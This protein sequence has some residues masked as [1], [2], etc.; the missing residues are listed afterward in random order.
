MALSKRDLDELRPV[1]QSSVLKVL[2]I[3]EPSVVIAAVN[4]IGQRMSKT[5]TVDM[6]KPLLEDSAERFVETLFVDVAGFQVGNRASKRTTKEDDGYEG[7][8]KRSKLSHFPGEEENGVKFAKSQPEALR[9][10]A[11][12]KA[13]KA[14][15]IQARIQATMM[16]AGLGGLKLPPMPGIP[17]APAIPKV[18]ATK[19][20]IS[21]MKSPPS[22][23]TKPA[24]LILD[25][26]G[27]TIDKSGR[28]II[29]PQHRPTIKANIRAKRREEFKVNQQEKPQDLSSDSNK[30]F[31]PRVVP[32]VGRGN[33]KSFKFHDQGKF[34]QVAQ[35]I[36]AK[37]QLE[38]L[39]NEISQAAK[40]T[41]IT[42]ATKL[43]LITPKRELK[44]NEIPGVEWWDSFILPTETYADVSKGTA[45]A[46]G[47]DKLVGITNLVEHPIQIEPPAEKKDV[48]L[49]IYLTKK[50]MKK[51]RRQRRREA[52]KE[53]TEKIRMGLEPPP[54]PKV[55]M[56]NLMRVLGT[57]A[58]QDPTKVEAHVRAQMEKRQRTHEE[59]NAARK[60]TTEQR[61]EKKE[62]KMREDTSTGVTV[63]VYRVLNLNNPAKRFK[64]EANAKQ[65]QMTGIAVVHK[66]MNC[67]V[68]EGGPKQQKKFQRLMLHRIKWGEDKRSK[69]DD[70]DSGDEAVKSNHCQLMWSGMIKQRNFSDLHFKLC[71]TEAMAR[72]QFK[73]HNVEHYWGLVHSQSVLDSTD[74]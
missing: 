38:K 68:V 37:S 48:E 46:S 40:K 17:Q 4:C 15:E 22:V 50:E 31:D 65:L 59:T 45:Q 54:E 26:Q 56:A 8:K 11:L 70:D 28:V 74:T 2:G 60:L 10:D 23:L 57:E 13:K 18:P 20:D 27:R 62:R 21:D 43:A 66:D 1:V 5:K 72:E 52:L 58:V 63:N 41:G 64:V 14:A 42:S 30:F 3:N 12:E 32:V 29:L 49:P 24:P 36:R 39:Q 73:K 33:R 44:E 71:P 7:H 47:T 61:K 16:S 69:H 55:R 25:E 35:R 53:T 6:L 51:L 19:E 67:V 9:N 34:E